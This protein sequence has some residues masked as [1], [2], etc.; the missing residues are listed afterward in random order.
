M[1]LKQAGLILGAVMV[2]VAS[3]ADPVAMSF[4][5]TAL[6]NALSYEVGDS[7]TFNIVIS[8]NYT[9]GNGDM[10]TS[11]ANTWLATNDTSTSSMLQDFSG[12]NTSGS[13][14][15][16]SFPKW[17]NMV[18][19]NYEGQDILQL[20]VNI[21]YNQSGVIF[22]TDNSTP[23]TLSEL[24]LHRIQLVW[25]LPTGTLDYSDTS[26]VSPA[27]WLSANAT[28]LSSNFTACQIGMSGYNTTTYMNQ[29]S[30]TDVTVSPV[31]E[32]ATAGLLAI[33]GLVLV[34]CRRM[35]K[36]YGM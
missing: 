2:A 7:C 11:S 29:F 6:G 20:T 22:P 14:T 17:E 32:P 24:E 9:G 33:S 26:F 27:S 5:G 28:A 10:F 34:G 1:K 13:F 25:Y 23:N 15:P 12:G 16:A 18:S 31:P 3:F 21:E 35:R 8:D 19:F 36:F 30:V 4:T